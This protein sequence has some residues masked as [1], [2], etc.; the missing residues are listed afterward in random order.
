MAKFEGMPTRETVVRRRTRPP[1]ASKVAF[2][3][4]VRDLRRPASEV[5]AKQGEAHERRAA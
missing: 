1:G 2:L 4:P 3:P 5:R